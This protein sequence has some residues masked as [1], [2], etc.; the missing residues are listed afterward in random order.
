MG[1]TLVELEQILRSSKEKLTQDE[2]HVLRSC[3]ARAVRDFTFSACLV[4]GITW[5][6]TRRLAYAHR[7][8]L[9]GGAAI[10]FGMWRFDRSLNSCLDQILALEGSRM[11]RE[12]AKLILTKYQDDPWRMQLVKK[13]FYSERVFNDANP[14]KPLSRWR[15]RHFFGDTNTHKP[16]EDEEGTFEKTNS[17]HDDSNELESSSESYTPKEVPKTSEDF[18]PNPLD[19]ILG[20]PGTDSGSSETISPSPKRRNRA[21]RRLHRKNH[22]PHN[23]SLK[24]ELVE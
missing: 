2:E 7:F 4:S 13:H 22:I 9:S 16:R 6:A 5:T 17:K 1:D 10:L 3:K 8:N 19:Y 24:A 21:H 20:F 12:L 18:V 11:Q 15:Q 23:V 14:E